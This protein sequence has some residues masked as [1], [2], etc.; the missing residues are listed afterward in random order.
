MKVSTSL[1]AASESAKFSYIA[2]GT[3]KRQPE[4]EPDAQFIEC[5][6]TIDEK[7]EKMGKGVNSDVGTGGM[8]TKISAAKIATA[9]GCDMII[10][11]GENI[12]VIHQ[13]MQGENAGT[14]F[15]EH[16]ADEFHLIDYIKTEQYQ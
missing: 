8:A 16:R 13:I 10:A 5:V 1:L 14:I 3:A 6:E 9:S 11:N 12:A 15:K 2:A 4:R 7:L